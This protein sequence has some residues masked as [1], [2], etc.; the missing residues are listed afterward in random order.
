[1]SGD[2]DEAL[3]LARHAVTELPEDPAVHE[4]LSLAL[5]ASKDYR[6]AASEAHA[7]LALGPPIDWPALSRHY[8]NAKTYADQLRALETYVQMNPRAAEGRFLLADHYMMTGNKDAAIRQLAETVAINPADKLAGNLM[9]Q[10]NR[11]ETANTARPSKSGST[12]R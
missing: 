1:M 8:E 11:S 2:Y 4:L 7:A 6:G 10:L 12:L 5:F 3:R 9:N